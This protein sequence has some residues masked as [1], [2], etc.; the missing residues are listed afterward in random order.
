MTAAFCDATP[1]AVIAVKLP[2]QSQNALIWTFFGRSMQDV[3]ALAHNTANDSR[4]KILLLL[5]S[6]TPPEQVYSTT[7]NSCCHTPSTA[8]SFSTCWLCW[9]G[10]GVLT[11]GP[12]Q[13][14][15]LRCGNVVDTRVLCVLSLALFWV[16]LRYYC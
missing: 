1:M 11:S 10:Q 15:S 2:L 8:M 13:M 6:G 14:K 5:P 9:A 4:M 16:R 7:R 3:R 12:L